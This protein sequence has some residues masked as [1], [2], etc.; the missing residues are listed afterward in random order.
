MIHVCCNGVSDGNYALVMGLSN[1]GI[2]HTSTQTS[3]I[4]FVLT[5]IKSITNN[6]SSETFK[7]I[8]QYWHRHNRYLKSRKKC[9]F[10]V[11]RK[12]RNLSFKCIF[13]FQITSIN[14]QFNFNKT[15]DYSFI[16]IVFPASSACILEGH[17]KI[18]AMINF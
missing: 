10:D 11:Y 3:S 8:L 9:N 2:I 14:E 12:I 18:N 17:E 6:Y 16:F 15:K 13:Q 7:D 1:N 4:I 5:L